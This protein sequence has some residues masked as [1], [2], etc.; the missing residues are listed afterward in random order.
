MD[1]YN[2]KNNNLTY[3]IVNFTATATLCT[4]YPFLGVFFYSILSDQIDLKWLLF[5]GRSLIKD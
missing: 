3:T 1:K 4:F 2:L 5:V